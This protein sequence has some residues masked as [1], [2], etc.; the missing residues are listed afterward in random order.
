MCAAV[1]LALTA[2]GA[3]TRLPTHALDSGGLGLALYSNNA[4]SNSNLYASAAQLDDD[5]DNG[6]E[7][8]Y[9]VLL[10]IDPSDERQHILPSLERRGIECRMLHSAAAAAKIVELDPSVAD[11][12]RENIA[13]P[14]GMESEWAAEELP[15][16]IVIVGVL[17]GSDGGLADAERLQDALVPHRSNGVN[18]ARRDKYLM[19]EVMRAA[20]LASQ[21]QAVTADWAATKAFI[22]TQQLP[23]VLKPRRG[24]ASVLV[25]LAQSEDEAERMDA[26]LR[27]SSV[28]IE[29]LDVESNV[30]VQQHVG[31]DEWVVDTVSANGEHKALALW[32]YDKG[33][34]NGAPFVYFSDELRP[35]E[36]AVERALIGYAFDALDALGWRWGPCHMEIKLAPNIPPGRRDRERDLGESDVQTGAEASDE[37]AGADAR[38][39]DGT[40]PLTPVLIEVNA[41]RWNGVDFQQLTSLCTGYDAYE[42][43]LDAYLDDDAWADT[44]RLPPT[45]LRGHARLVKLVSSVAGTLRRDPAE[46]HAEA[47]AAM[48]SLMRFEPEPSSVGEH[49]DLTVDLASAAGFAY[50][51]HADEATLTADYQTLREL[52]PRLFDVGADGAE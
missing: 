23:V 50:L 7:D 6:E 18:P 51:L 11:R 48:P 20:G 21:Q 40:L 14:A 31:G 39:A 2:L 26:V 25:G 27:D 35:M 30:V 17:C 22:A 29:R 32:R 36:G 37:Q 12:V 19:V 41:G 43:T 38:A 24:Q 28:S 47:L 8:E 3:G 33:R 45:S 52:Q 5:D 34:A 10:Y 44:P 1:V 4:R 16:G 13:P 46:A 9:R 42:A 49:V 15:E